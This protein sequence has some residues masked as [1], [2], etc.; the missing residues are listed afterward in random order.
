MEGARRAAWASKFWNERYSGAVP[1]A[2]LEVAVFSAGGE[3][4]CQRAGGLDLIVEVVFEV[5]D[6]GIHFDLRPKG[7]VLGDPEHLREGI[8]LAFGSCLPGAARAA[9]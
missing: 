2:S 1:A 7:V 3:K 8:E 4:L 6:R 5:E 9:G